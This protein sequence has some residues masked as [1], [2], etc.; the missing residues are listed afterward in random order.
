MRLATTILAIL[1]ALGLNAAQTE[2]VE[3]T[4][5]ATGT[6]TQNIDF[7]GTT[8]LN[9]VDLSASG[10]AVK[11]NLTATTDPSATDDT[12]GSYAVGSV[13]WNGTGDRV[14]LC[15]DA[16]DDAAV[17]LQLPGDASPAQGEVLYADSNG[18]WIAL[19]VGSSGQ[20]LQT[21]GA[22]ANPQWATPAGAGDMLRSTYDVD[23]DG[24]VDAAA[25]EQN[26]GTD[27][28]ADL[29][30]ETH[31]SEHEQG[32]AD[33]IDG[34][35]LDID[36]TPSNYTPS[37]VPAEADN[38]DDLA[39]HLQGID[40]ALGASASNAFT[41]INAS[42]GSDPAADSATDTLAVTGGT[43][44]TVTGDSGTDT[45]TIA[46]D[47]DL[48]GGTTLGGAA[49][50]TGAEDDTPDDD[51]EV[52]D[53]ITVNPVNATTETAI[54]AVVDLQ[55]LQGAVTDG[56]VPDAI[57]V[58][59]VN[60]TT[61]TA[62]E[63]VVDLQDLQG[64]VTDGQVP[65]AITR[66]TE[67]D[68]AAE[69]NAATTDDDFVTLTGAQSI[70]GLKN[71][72]ADATGALGSYDLAVGDVTTPD[73][74]S[75]QLGGAAIYRTSAGPAG[76]DFDG[77]VLFRQESALGVGNDP[78]I[79]FAFME[80]GNTVRF[81]IPES[82][83]GNA[84]AMFRSVSI[85]GPYNQVTGNVQMTGDQWTTYD[86]N[87]DFDAGSSGAD[88][89]VQDDL[90]VEGEIYTH[91][92][93]LMDADDANQFTISAASQTASHGFQFP[94]DEIASADMIVGT[95]AG[96]F[97]YVAMSS[98]ATMTSGGVVTVANDSHNH[99]TTTLSG[100]DIS[101]DTNLA[102]GDGITLTG[103]TLSGIVIQYSITHVT[104][105]ASTATVIPFD[106]T[107]PQSSEG[108]EYTTVAF[109]PVSATSTVLIRVTG[110]CSQSST[111][112]MVIA[113]F[114]DSDTD[115]ID[116]VSMKSSANNVMMPFTL[117]YSYAPGST[118][119]ITFKIRYGPTVN[120]G[121]MNSTGGS[122]LFSTTDSVT[123]VIMELE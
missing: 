42:S 14:W 99:T 18:H 77:A 115:A 119:A 33:E 8:K 98:D 12:D 95:G 19:G 7:T 89:F 34:D 5:D 103:D 13:W 55:D 37:V 100:I 29:E 64:A 72:I 52:P 96:T 60:A 20:Y 66:D 3:R 11:H 43:D 90:E 68:T 108:A 54:E 82:G 76:M 70:T 75:L 26:A 41:T 88:L 2:P 15:L 58:N 94:D 123:I 114:K 109:T 56:Q 6:I 113:L 16:S 30:E 65:A 120:T 85:A 23:T 102:A 28:S 93:I 87:L 49:I 106:D 48:T 112:H 63:A 81:A 53:A 71:A 80:G 44:I 1:T 121:Y 111:N 74:G 10:A 117:E 91:G 35:N 40:D 36:L 22:G 47:G 78:G 105:I 27:I 31:A 92:T 61:E 97:G 38:V 67:W 50:Q 110:H 73:Y 51:S 79:E 21:Q 84:M 107:I 118:S 46:L 122:S 24:N 116:A 4:K 39:A 104:S 17:W 62:I 57:T 9:G 45:I 69:I 25:V 59:P 32:A 83:A 86:T 101:D